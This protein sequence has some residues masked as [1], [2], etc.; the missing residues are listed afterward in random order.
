MKF[1][2]VTQ[3]Y[4]RKDGDELS[5]VKQVILEGQATERYGLDSFGVAEQHFKFPTNSTGAIDV[6]MSWVAATTE[7]IRLK[8]A[9]VIP[10][11]HHPLNVAERWATIDTLSGGRVDFGIGRGN[12]PKTADAFEVPIPETNARTIEALEII[13]KAWTQNEFSHHGTYWN[14]DDVR[15]TPHPVQS[16]HP[17]LSM[18]SVSVGSC[19]Q[20]GSLRLGLMGASNNLEWHQIEDRLNAYRAAWETGTA[21][22]HATP[23]SEVTMFA[24]LHVAKSN[25]LAREQVE[26]GIV[27]YTNRAMLQDIKNHELTYGTSKG[28][29]TT[30]QFYDNF[31]GLLDLTALAVGD[32]DYAIE[33]ILKLAEYEIDELVFHI[34]YAPHDEL[35]E[36]IRLVGEEVVPAVK[37]ELAARDARRQVAA[38]GS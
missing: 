38:A 35:L 32:P 34:D 1:G 16:A 8:P 18:A 13:V 23:N 30:G 27:E 10:A 5:R 7:R 11:L 12:T 14:F 15:L 20:A 37:Q 2:I 3:G 17:P 6:I 36:C 28:M 26:F 21:I 33:K 4:I 31:D 24:P 29:D 19:A 22:E 9:A 25:Q